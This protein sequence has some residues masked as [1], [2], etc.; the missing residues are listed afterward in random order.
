M[1]RIRCLFCF[2]TWRQSGQMRKGGK[3]YAT[4]HCAFCS[5]AGKLEE[6]IHGGTSVAVGGESCSTLL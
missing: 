5:K 1:R 3:T 4:K 6:L 2:H